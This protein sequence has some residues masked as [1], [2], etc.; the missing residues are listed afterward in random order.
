MNKSINI[1]ARLLWEYDINTF[2]FEKNYRIVIERVIQRGTPFE[3]REIVEFYGK[4]K[5][6]EVTNWS[7]QLFP[8]DKN[9]VPIFLES[10]LL[11]VL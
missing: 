8:Q 10:P 5:I 3:W 7:K 11:Y 4:E 2:N 1:D 9:F 6:L